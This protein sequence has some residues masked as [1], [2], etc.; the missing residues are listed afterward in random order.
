MPPQIITS[1][2]FHAV[3]ISANRTSPPP[4]QCE[5]RG[6][7]SASLLSPFLKSA[8][9]KLTVFTTYHTL[10]NCILIITRLFDFC[11]SKI[12]NFSFFFM[13]F[14]VT[15]LLPVF[16]LLILHYTNKCFCN[17]CTNVQLSSQNYIRNVRR[18]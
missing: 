7:C 3:G 16:Y 12:K 6:A 1:R 2:S 15:F 17:L 10:Y 4:V 8:V 13:F 18:F 14:F 9:Y 11:N 5:I